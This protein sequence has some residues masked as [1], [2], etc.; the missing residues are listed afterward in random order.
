MKTAQ[1][2]ADLMFGDAGIVPDKG[3]L[4]RL[5]K[6][7]G[8]RFYS[9]MDFGFSHHF[10]TATVAVWGDRAFVVDCI[11]AKGLELDDKL[12]ISQPL[13]TI[14][15]A[16]IYGDTSRPDDI[17]TFRRKGFKMRD[18]SKSAG[19]V[20]YGIEITRMLISSGDGVPRVFF[21]ADDPGVEY[22]FRQMGDYSFQTDMAGE[23]TEEPLKENDDAVDAL[24]YVLMNVFAPR[25]NIKV[26]SETR[27]DM[28]GEQASSEWMDDYMTQMNN[29]VRSLTDGGGV[30]ETNNGP[31][32]I[33]SGNVLWTDGE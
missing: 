23:P 13:K 16:T 11:S 12:Q 28:T 31:K 22:L 29:L 9:G 3:T 6:S 14:Y 21:L 17:K 20:K 33:R 27:I 15:D 24:R 26:D 5:M 18:W 25:G 1:E 4:I 10:A 32:I 8:V 7:K 19:S 2:I 30:S